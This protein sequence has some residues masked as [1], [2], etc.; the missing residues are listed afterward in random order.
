VTLGAGL[1][2]VPPSR[3]CSGRSSPHPLLAARSGVGRPDELTQLV[4]EAVL[5][6]PLDAVLQLV[7]LL[8]GILIDEGG[9]PHQLV[10]REQRRVAGDEK[11]SRAGVGP[12]AGSSAG[13]RES[14]HAVRLLSSMER[15][16]V[17]PCPR[18]LARRGGAI[19]AGAQ[20]P[21]RPA[22]LAPPSRKGKRGPAAPDRP[23]DRPTQ[24]GGSRDGGA[25]LLG[26]GAVTS[27]H[28][29]QRPAR[30]AVIGPTSPCGQPDVWDAIASDPVEDRDPIDGEQ[31]GSLGG[32]QQRPMAYCGARSLGAIAAR[33]GTSGPFRPGPWHAP[34]VAPCSRNRKQNCAFA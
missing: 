33:H 26:Q 19:F 15:V 8:C 29:Q 25:V 23:S 2:S 12:L 14:P 13:R 10:D 3:H 17:G 5:D 7:S 30:D 21:A 27:E 18:P 28:A 34:T 32:G 4:D 20:T 24:L 22:K 11:V 9:S 6:Q 31:S 1:G 16:S